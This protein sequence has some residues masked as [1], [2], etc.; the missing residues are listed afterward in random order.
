MLKNTRFGAGIFV[1]CIL[2]LAGSP[3]GLAQ[4]ISVRTNVLWDAVAE[5]NLGFELQ[6]GEHWSVGVDAGLKAWPRWLAWDWDTADATHWRNFAVVPEVR[7]Y[8]NQV[9]RGFFAGADA[10]YTHYNIGNVTFPFGLYPDAKDFRLQGSFWGGGLFVG[11]AWWPWDHWRLELEAGA[12][13]GLAAYDRY[14]CPHCGTKL[15]EDR[16][17]GVVPKLAVNVAWNPVGKD[18]HQAAAPSRMVVSGRDTI[19]VL[20]P[21]VA[22]VV[23]LK[24]VQAPVTEADHLAQDNDW[25][26]PIE[27][28]RPLD[29]LTRPGRDSLMYINFAESSDVLKREYPL[30]PVKDLHRNARV[31]DQLQKAI[32]TIRDAETTEE[33][34]ISIVGLASIDGPQELNDSLSVRRA[35]AVA[36]YLNEKTFVSR[37][38]FEVIGKGEAWDWFRAQV[39]AQPEGHR[40]LLEIL[41]NEPDPDKRERLIKADPQLYKE[42]KE[43]FLADQ[44]NSGYIRIYYSNRPEPTTQKWNT[45]VMEL[46]KGKRYH[47]AI[48]AV[49]ADETLLSRVEEDAEAT[50]AYG[51]ALYFTALDNKD[52]DAEARAIGLLQKAARMGSEAA[53][54]NLKGIETYGP[55]RKEY[56]AWKEIMKQ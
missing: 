28:Y 24:D 50:N 19:T 5:P 20:T 6:T 31:L 35:R 21:P 32:E 7:Y 45:N 34:L 17:V 22:F 38:C 25:V 27:K 48:R 10:V 49:E 51:V 1:S 56:E 44:R 46:L 3:K 11:Y 9:F 55:A 33:L 14:D 37:R 43:E 13:M 53:R 39:E 29:Y 42:V 8:V 52:Q 4:E 18:K 2:L 23:H 12:A 41:D 47:D 15:A 30:K 16:K 40:K 54:E 36:N 26:I